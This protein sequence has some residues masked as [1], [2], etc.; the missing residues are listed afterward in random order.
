MN[1]RFGY[2]IR[3]FCIETAGYIADLYGYDMQVLYDYVHHY[4]G[5]ED[6]LISDEYI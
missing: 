3:D 5:M 6:D 4:P 1:V 2:L